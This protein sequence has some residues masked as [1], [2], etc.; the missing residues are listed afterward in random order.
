[1]KGR[2]RS[3]YGHTKMLIRYFTVLAENSKPGIRGPVSFGSYGRNK[4]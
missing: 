1:M 4:I 3:L 2:I